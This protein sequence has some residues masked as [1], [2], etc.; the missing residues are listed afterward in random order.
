ME[1]FFTKNFTTFTTQIG[2]K[3]K[4]YSYK[5]INQIS[6]DLYLL[7]Y[8]DEIINVIKNYGGTNICVHRRSYSFDLPDDKEFSNK[9][10][11]SLGREIAAINDIG[12]YVRVFRYKLSNGKEAKSGQLFRIQESL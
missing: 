11:R 6:E 5:L 12:C 10:K 7:D 8:E 4:T 2:E 3:M 9:M 1:K